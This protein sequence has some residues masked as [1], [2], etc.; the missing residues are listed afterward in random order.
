MREPGG[1]DRIPQGVPT[2]SATGDDS[3]SGTASFDDVPLARDDGIARD[4]AT[5]DHPVRTPDHAT[6]T[7]EERS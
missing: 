5:D 2:A 3:D 7:T 4:D 6:T 1:S